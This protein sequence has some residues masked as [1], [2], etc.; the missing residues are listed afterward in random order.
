MKTPNGG[1]HAIELQKLV[2]RLLKVPPGNPHDVP[3]ERGSGLFAC[4][5]S[6]PRPAPQW[7]LTHGLRATRSTVSKNFTA[8]V[9][10]PNSLPFY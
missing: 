4:Q 2:V 5:R 9:L 7:P 8:K 10:R 1:V 6:D 3:A